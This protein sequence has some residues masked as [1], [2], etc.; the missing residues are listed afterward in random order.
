M[1]CAINPTN[2][3]ACETGSTHREDH[4]LIDNTCPCE[5]GYY[6]VNISKNCAK[7]MNQCKDCVNG[8]ECTICELVGTF[9]I[10]KIATEK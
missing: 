10:D 7:C 8:Y 9:R 6:G 4:S 5:I 2:C 3:T 1:N